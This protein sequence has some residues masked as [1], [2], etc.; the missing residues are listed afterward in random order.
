MDIKKFLF[1]VWY[2]VSEPLRDSPNLIK[3]LFDFKIWQWACVSLA[4]Y[5]AWFN[6]LNY[7]KWSL[8]GFVVFYYA[9]KIKSGEHNRIWK[10]K[11][12]KN[13]LK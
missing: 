5:F 10:E 12:Y 2:Y 6:N 11:M 8:I 3:T 13:K 9:N 7:T 1:S 4:F